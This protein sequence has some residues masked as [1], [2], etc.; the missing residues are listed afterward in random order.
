M[1]E[2]WRRGEEL[3]LV[4]ATGTT[5]VPKRRHELVEFVSSLNSR[6][7]CVEMV[8][9]VRSNVFRLVLPSHLKRVPFPVLSA[10]LCIFSLSHTRNIGRTA[11]EGST[12]QAEVDVCRVLES[13]ILLFV[14]YVTMFSWFWLDC[15]SLK[16]VITHIIPAGKHCC[17]YFHINIKIS[18]AV[19]EGT[20]C[21]LPSGL[22]GVYAFCRGVSGIV[23]GCVCV[24]GHS[25][26]FPNHILS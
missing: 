11:V 20:P 26:T 1:S 18:I 12:K 5:F 15:F 8:M 6:S 19:S 10:S 3:I 22:A 9:R 14:S 21:S 17:C 25:L 7:G 16:T 2:S 4:L 24:F 13:T 23:N